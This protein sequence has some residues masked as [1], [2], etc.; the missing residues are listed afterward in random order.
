MLKVSLYCSCHTPLGYLWMIC[1]WKKT[2]TCY[3]VALCADPQFIHS[4]KPTRFKLHS[5]YGI[6]WK[7]YFLLTD[8]LCGILC[9]WLTDISVNKEPSR[10]IKLV[11]N[12]W[13]Q[14]FKVT[15]EMA[16]SHIHAHV[17]GPE[18]SLEW[19]CT[20]G[21]RAASKNRAGRLWQ[22]LPSLASCC[23]V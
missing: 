16:S 14:T 3:I 6:F 15:S 23:A 17:F 11:W 2:Y 1:S 10:F 12:I 21:A 18:F 13:K 20:A 9:L 4:L 19:K 8:S 22:I 5:L 7:A